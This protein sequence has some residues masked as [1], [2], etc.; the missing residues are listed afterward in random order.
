MLGE[1]SQ[2]IDTIAI[3]YLKNGKRRYGKRMALARRVKTTRSSENCC[4]CV[5][6]QGARVALEEEMVELQR[7][8]G[9]LLRSLSDEAWAEVREKCMVAMENST[10]EGQILQQRSKEVSPQRALSV[11]E[12]FQ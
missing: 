11:A 12:S 1:T 4:R 10:A 8:Q 3:K 5:Y 2:I 6:V 9:V 7:R